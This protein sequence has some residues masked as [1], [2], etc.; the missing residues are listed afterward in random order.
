MF[1]KK[2]RKRI[3]LLLLISLQ[4]VGSDPRRPFDDKELSSSSLRIETTSVMRAATSMIRDSVTSLEFVTGA[5]LQERCL[6]QLK[7]FGCLGGS[8]MCDVVC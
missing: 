8:T 3:S 7:L 5:E 1:E 6:G 4:L 2:L